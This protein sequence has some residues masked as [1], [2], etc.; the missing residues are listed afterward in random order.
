MPRSPKLGYGSVRTFMRARG[1]DAWNRVRT[2]I[3]GA[4][5]DMPNEGARGDQPKGIAGRAAQPRTGTTA[6]VYSE[7][8]HDTPMLPV[9]REMLGPSEQ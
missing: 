7:S 3:V 5:S 9:P 2:P 6:W 1:V 8:R 4:D